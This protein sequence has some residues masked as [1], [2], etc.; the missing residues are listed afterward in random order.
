MTLGLRVRLSLMMALVYGVMGS[1]FPLLAVHLK[2]LGLSGQ[3][4]GW[5]FATFALGSL[6]A[7]LWIGRL[8]DR[9]IEAQ[10]LLGR[11]F[12]AASAILALIASGWIQSASGMLGLFLIYWMIVA[13]AMSLSTTIA[14]RNLPKPGEQFSGVRLW[15]TIGWMLAGWV[16]AQVMAWTGSDASGRG[17]FEAF[18]VGSTLAIALAL[19]S[20]RLPRTPPLAT[21]SSDGRGWAEAIDDVKVL[22]RGRP[23]VALYFGTAFG[24]TL[25]LP[26][27][28][29]VQPTYLETAGLPRPWIAP[30][31]T[32]GQMSEIG[33]L[34]SLPWMLRRWGYRG[35]MAVGI[36]A[37]VLR[38]GSL[39]LDPPLWLAIAGIPLH[40]FAIAWFT[41]PGVMFLDAHAPADRRAT[42]QGLNVVVTAGLGALLGN[43]IAGAIMD[44]SGERYP[45]VFAVPFGVNASL[46]LIWGV[47]GR[48]LRSRHRS[49]R[50]APV[51]EQAGAAES[52]SEAERPAVPQRKPVEGSEHN[53]EMDRQ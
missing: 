30:A 41:I 10:R 25:T 11:I 48:R 3:Q 28:F 16:V 40:G 20:T 53:T 14:L 27:M 34:W 42:A 52:S 5:V 13:P 43:L 33:A 7:P 1:W 47:L 17:A 18:A 37:W 19:Y 12:A 38:Y 51:A 6:T 50:G 21:S 31:M 49:E 29:Q 46:L 15:G 8:A 24:V 35:T 9:W 36:S 4:R 26:Y 44:L 45:V 22:L 32:M 2:D 39:C 23:T